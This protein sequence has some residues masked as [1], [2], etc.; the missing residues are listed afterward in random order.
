MDLRKG[1]GEPNP[2]APSPVSGD[3]PGEPE[4][5]LAELVGDFVTDVVASLAEGLANLLNPW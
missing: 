2:A 4:S 3:D 5:T 1:T